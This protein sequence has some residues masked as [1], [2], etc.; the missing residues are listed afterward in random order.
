[1]ISVVLHL[2]S[3]LML[4]FASA[5]SSLIQY[6]SGKSRACII[7]HALESGVLQLY[8]MYIACQNQKSNLSLNQNEMRKQ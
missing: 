5:L 8:D 6:F 1:M 3:L 2:S 7:I 4:V